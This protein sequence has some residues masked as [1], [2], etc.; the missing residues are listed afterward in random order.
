MMDASN[1]LVGYRIKFIQKANNQEAFSINYS[2][3]YQV[4]RGE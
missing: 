3:Y 2:V 4:D 1:R